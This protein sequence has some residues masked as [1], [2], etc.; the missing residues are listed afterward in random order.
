MTPAPLVAAALV[1][2]LALAPSAATSGARVHGNNFFSN[3]R[4]SHISNDDPIVYPGQPG[5][6]HSHTFFGNRSTSAASTLHSL[7]AAATTCKPRSDTAAY[8]VPTLYDHGRVVR[9]SKAALYYIVRAR[10]TIA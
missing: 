1:L 4:L 6:S 5:R 7:R 9:P 2:A 10:T 8:W 3:C